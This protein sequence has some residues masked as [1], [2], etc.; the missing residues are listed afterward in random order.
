VDDANLWTQALGALQAGQRGKA[1]RLLY[2]LVSLEPDHR[3][4][5][6]LLTTLA[7]T[8]SAC[9][10]CL[11]QAQQL[12][13]ANRGLQ[14][15]VIALH[16]APPVLAVPPSRA[17][18]PSADRWPHPTRRAVRPGLSQLRQWAAM[19][20]THALPRIA[21]YTLVKGI[22]LVLTVI[23]GVYLTIL[24]A[25]LGGGVDEIF[26]GMITQTL[27][28]RVQG[29]WLDDVPTE[30]RTQ[31]LEQAEWEMEEAYGLHEPFM[32][33][34]ARWLVNGLTLNLGETFL[35]GFFEGVW[36][37]ADQAV[38]SLV[39]QRLPYTLLLVGASNVLIFVATVGV[40]LVLS[41]RYGGLMDRT[42][43]TL[44]ALTSAPSWIFGVILVVVVAGRLQLLPFP[45]AIDTQYAAL[46]PEFGRLLLT[47]MIFPV[48]AITL[49][50]FFTG[51]YTWRT[52]FVLYSGEDYVE[53]AKAKGL[54]PRALERRY[55]LRP[56]LPY[57]ITAFAL[58][59]IGVWEG[60]IALEILFYWPGIGPLFLQAIQRFNTPLIVAVV[61]V[62]AYL[63]AITVFVLDILYA[64]VDPRVRVGSNGPTVEAARRRTTR[65]FRRRRNPRAS[66]GQ[67]QVSPQQPNPP[68]PKVSFSQ[69]I[70][71]LGSHTGRLR[72]ALRELARYPSAILGLVII[73][74]LIGVSIYTLLTIP[75]SQAIQQWQ[76]H[77]TDEG[78]STA[79]QNPKNA[80]PVWVNLFRRDKLPETIRLTTRAGSI[81]KN[82]E[83][84]GEDTIDITF[85]FTFD[86]PYGDFP[87]QLLLFFESEYQQKAPHLSLTWLTPDGREISFPSFSAERLKT[88]D[89]SNDERLQRRLGGLPAVQGLF[90]DPDA[91]PPVPLR[92]SYEL[93]VGG[94][95][96]E[97]ESDVDAE[98]VLYGRVS[99]LAGTDNHRRDLTVALLWGTPVALAFGL[100]GAVVTSL[101]AMLIATVGVW[102]GGWLDELIQRITEVNMILPTLPIAI[103]VYILYSKS[104][105]AILGV[106]ILLSIFGNS[107]KNYRA[108]LLQMKD[109]AYIEGAQAYGASDGR[110][111]WRYLVPRMVPVLL[112]QLVTMVPAFVFYEATLAF[113]GVSDPQLPTWGKLIY[114]AISNGAFQGHYYWIAQ[115]IALLLVTGLAFALLGFALERMVNPRLMDQ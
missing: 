14:R 101:F 106:I 51:V 111:I 87:E 80:M 35:L 38:Q 72:I 110:I 114:D 50:T 66:I 4:A 49:S 112:P 55:V 77:S 68:R 105:W 54:A 59:V 73:L 113:L 97:A 96:F 82:Y 48:A 28:G 71:G 108:A 62:F 24:V 109:A 6:V 52:F 5:W 60:A 15:A 2:Q 33:R 107:I 79:Y 34:S 95:V 56:S 40:A 76:A 92:G 85:S 58:M 17:V 70:K 53:M 47:Q 8:R 31:I 57:V 44:A 41:R 46:T 84:V 42:M 102:Y 90:G 81:P 100:L 61:V 19:I 89:V 94:L 99:G 103:M 30:Q 63:L 11:E 104:I 67:E 22:S 93:R 20:A 16:K 45:K 12:D 98:F 86:Y 65:R 115:P 9:L 3:M 32:L 26:R 13:P 21:K 18:V 36:R 78:K 7:P 75:A 37:G 10:V 74:A 91:D 83:R 43:V 29:G 69:R 25:N 23:L 1:R 39:L 88:Y 64:L 27:M